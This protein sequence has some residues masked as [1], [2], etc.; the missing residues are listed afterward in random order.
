MPPSNESRKSR[1]TRRKRREPAYITC[2]L[3]HGP[4][5]E[6]WAKAAQ[7]KLQIVQWWMDSIT[8][9]TP[10]ETN[11]SGHRFYARF[12]SWYHSEGKRELTTVVKEDT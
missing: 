11:R 5:P 12:M 6:N 10:P 8:G 3:V 4:K 2:L 1:K 9:N 7:Y